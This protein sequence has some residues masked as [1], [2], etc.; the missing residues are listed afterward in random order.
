MPIIRKGSHAIHFAHVPR[1]AGRALIQAFSKAGWVPDYHIPAT[2]EMHPHPTF[3]EQREEILSIPS[4]ATVRDPVDRFIS[5]CKFE[6]LC[7]SEEA[8]VSMLRNQVHRPSVPQRHFLP[9]SDFIA[10]HTRVFKYES[11][12]P[13]LVEFLKFSGLMRSGDELARLN[14]GAAVYEV[15]KDKVSQDLLK[16][17]RWYIQDY[18]AFGYIGSKS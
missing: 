1:V 14:P 10:P 4:F 11:E 8:V 7:E 5:A 15:N 12:I 17:R 13:Q 18:R 6:G 9:Q 3:E 2:G 16:V